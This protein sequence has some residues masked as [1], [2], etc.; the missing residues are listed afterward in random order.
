MET[1]LSY[2]MTSLKDKYDLPNLELQN[3]LVAL[4]RSVLQ[5]LH[6]KSLS[7][8]QVAQALSQTM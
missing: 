5:A 1:T 6:A 3:L 7:S 8:H 2:I 4:Y